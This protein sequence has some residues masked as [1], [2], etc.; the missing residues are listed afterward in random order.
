M[1]LIPIFR[2]VSNSVKFFGTILCVLEK[3]KSPPSTESVVGCVYS[4]RDYPS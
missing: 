4:D 3:N 1:G 2:V